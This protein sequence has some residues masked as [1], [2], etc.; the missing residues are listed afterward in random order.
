ML[1]EVV[2][3]PASTPIAQAATQVSV[4][5]DR[6]ETVDNAVPDRPG[7][8]PGDTGHVREQRTERESPGSGGT[9]VPAGQV[10]HPPNPTPEELLRDLGRPGGSEHRREPTQ[11]L[12]GGRA[13]ARR[14]RQRNQPPPLVDPKTFREAGSHLPTTDPL[15]RHAELT[16]T[17]SP[18]GRKPE[19]SRRHQPPPLTTGGRKRGGKEKISHCEA[20]P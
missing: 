19:G 14:T 5:S 8:R 6:P 15:G 20:T 13:Q 7:R 2:L 12:G 1:T 16:N 3:R 17:P 18:S 10:V 4:V 9:G 11:P